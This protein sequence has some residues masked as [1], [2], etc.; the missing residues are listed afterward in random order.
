MPQIPILPQQ[1]NYT[2][3]TSQAATTSRATIQTAD[4]SEA[5]ESTDSDG[6]DDRLSWQA[7]S[8]RGKKRAWPR[9][10]KVPTM[11][12][13]KLQGRNNHPPQITI[14]NKFE[15]LRHADTEGNI[16]HER[17]DPALPSPIFVPGITNMQQLTA[18]IE[19]V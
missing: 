5:E 2:I 4:I 15:A 8:V 3:H 6:N 1:S 18:T 14:T 9:T 16:K 19:Q 10:T 7:V 11:K 12:K 17:K 13:N